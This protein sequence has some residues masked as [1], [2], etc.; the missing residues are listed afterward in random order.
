MSLTT[1]QNTSV[2][3]LT[4]SSGAS[5]WTFEDGVSGIQVSNATVHI[6]SDGA[7]SSGGNSFL[8]LDG[9]SV[10]SNQT[11]TVGTTTEYPIYLAAYGVPALKINTDGMVDLISAK[12]KINGDT[13]TANQVL[14]TDGNGNVSWTDPQTLPNSF[15]TISVSGQNN[16]VAE[17]TSD[18]L[19]LVAGTNI[20]IT[21]ND[22]TDEIT[23]N[24]TASGGVTDTDTFRPG[25]KGLPLTKSDATSNKARASSY[26][27]NDGG[28]AREIQVF[29]VKN[30]DAVDK[31]IFPSAKSDGT[32]VQVSVLDSDTDSHTLDAEEILT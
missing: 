19:T 28:Y 12:F 13:G 31:N 23:I 15:N 4:N 20:T 25:W 27:F 17:S 22:T 29:A 26:F 16:V 3:M 14:K 10:L 21:T 6:E 7:L 5:G 1:H 30:S 11:L 9:M 18:T 2:K 8:Y 32:T 24:S